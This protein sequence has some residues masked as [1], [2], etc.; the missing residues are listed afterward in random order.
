MTA[1]AAHVKAAT[2]RATVRL[3]RAGEI[4]KLPCEVCGTDSVS[5][6]H[7]DYTNPRDVA[8]L[9]RT[10]HTFADQGI[11]TTAMTADPSRGPEKAGPRR[12]YSRNTG[13]AIYTVS[14][15][16]PEA[17]L[18]RDLT[19]RFHFGTAADLIREA[20]RDLIAAKAPEMCAPD[21]FTARRRRKHDGW[22]D[23]DGDVRRWVAREVTIDDL[24]RSGLSKGGLYQ[25]IRTRAYE[26]GLISPAAGLSRDGEARVILAR[27]LM[28]E[29]PTPSNR[30]IAEVYLKHSH[31]SGAAQELKLSRQRLAQVIRVARMNIYMAEQVSAFPLSTY[32]TGLDL[33]A[34]SNGAIWKLTEGADFAE[35]VGNFITRLRAN[36]KARGMTVKTQRDRFDPKVIYIQLF[37][38]V[39]VSAPSI[40]GHTPEPSA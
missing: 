34:W 36:V 40:N 37:E 30:R 35:P 1:V 31:W 21:M 22:P 18:L 3:I 6:H 33:T 28:T 16:Q 4:V 13:K 14:L 39:K 24:M 23:F 12:F 17:L 8:W 19:E 32:K 26:L 10:H 27:W 2:R 11:A 38:P 20:L 29:A 7:R 9:C 5:V 15:S 25:R